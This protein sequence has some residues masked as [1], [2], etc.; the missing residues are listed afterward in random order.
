MHH[1]NKSHVRNVD[2]WKSLNA[3]IDLEILLHAVRTTIMQ[4]SNAK[5]Y[6]TERDQI[7]QSDNPVRTDGLLVPS[8]FL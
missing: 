7:K 3:W 1:Q 4:F 2:C 5:C 6:R 8:P